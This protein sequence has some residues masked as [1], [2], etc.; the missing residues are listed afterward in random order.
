M[1]ALQCDPH[2][3]EMNQATMS[4]VVCNAAATLR[5]SGDCRNR[6]TTLCQFPKVSDEPRG[7]FGTV[8]RACSPR[9]R[10]AFQVQVGTVCD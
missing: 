5:E 9:A 3:V 1:A 10:A 8:A 4:I 2:R 6:G 7:R